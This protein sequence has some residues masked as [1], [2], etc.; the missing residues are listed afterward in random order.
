MNITLKQTIYSSTTLQDLMQRVVNAVNA[1]D[2]TSY[3]KIVVGS[4]KVIHPNQWEV[5]LCYYAN[6]CPHLEC[7]DVS[8]ELSKFRVV[9]YWP[10]G[11]VV[12]CEC[13]QVFSYLQDQVTCTSCGTPFP[14]E[15]ITRAA[16]DAGDL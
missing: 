3:D 15:L 10:D 5:E 1:L 11:P 8:S 2:G 4:V 12:E 9:K 16:K 14:G 7:A 6:E 13:G